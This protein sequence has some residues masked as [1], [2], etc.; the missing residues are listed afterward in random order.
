L[1]AA[2]SDGDNDNVTV[3]L[4]DTRFTQTNNTFTM[5]TS[6]NSSA[7]FSVVFSATDGFD[8]V[9]TSIDVT[10]LPATDTDGDDIPD[11]T[12]NDDDG[13]GITDESDN[14]FGSANDISTNINNMNVEINGS[15]DLNRTMH[16]ALAVAFTAD[17]NTLVSFVHDFDT[18][19]LELYGVSI[20]SEEKE[21][22]N[23]VVTNVS[24]DNKTVSIDDSNTSSTA[25]CVQD[26][27]QASL[28]TMT[29]S[30]NGTDEYLVDCDGSD[31]DGYTCTDI[32]DVLVISGL[33]HSAVQE[34]CIDTDS[35]GYG[36]GC[37]L[38]DDCADD[39]AAV[40]PD[41]PEIA[42]NGIDDDCRSGDA[43][44]EAEVEE[45]VAAT[46]TATGSAGGGAGGTVERTSDEEASSSEETTETQQLSEDT[47][48][49]QDTEHTEEIITT[50][51]VT[52]EDDREG[53]SLTG[54]AVAFDGSRTIPS[55]LMIVFA[56]LAGVALLSA[57]AYVVVRR[58]R[59]TDK[60]FTLKD[61]LLDFY[62]GIKDLFRKY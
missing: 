35:D 11:F 56:V 37:S 7:F 51:A 5:N 52:S 8:T 41:A 53:D 50:T 22:G 18:A 25:V 33:Q 46:S 29:Y 30:C 15:S 12:D 58:Q 60:G 23:I 26:V 45:E 4:N 3:S 14:V 21:N 34:R 16:G 19:E 36:D 38:G 1:D 44:V 17:G 61:S 62:N 57:G 32:G 48:E 43:H 13:D 59:D 39:N 20:M 27:A 49:R 42:D 54:A 9:T 2:V 24:A 6:L 10:I 47:E 40:H 55:W 31:V 28:E